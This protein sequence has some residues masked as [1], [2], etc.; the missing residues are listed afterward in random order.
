MALLSQLVRGERERGPR[1]DARSSRE[2]KSAARDG[3]SLRRLLG[4]ARA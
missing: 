1:W 4:L 3:T 2:S